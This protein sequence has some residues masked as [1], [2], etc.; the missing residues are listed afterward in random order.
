M[1]RAYYSAA[2][3]VGLLQ[4]CV[5]YKYFYCFFFPFSEGSSTDRT[6]SDVIDPKSLRV[7]DNRSSSFH[8]L[9]R[10]RRRRSLYDNI[11]THYTYYNVYVGRY[12]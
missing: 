2:A 5:Q 1:G 12:T 11:I 6:G 4:D 7:K 8:P 3:S 9:A 10:L